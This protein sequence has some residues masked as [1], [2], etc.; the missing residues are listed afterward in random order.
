MRLLFITGNKGK[1]EEVKAALSFVEQFN[2]DLPEIQEIDSR[3]IIKFKLLEALRHKNAGF[4]VEDTSLHLD[5]LN[6][7][8]GPLIRWFL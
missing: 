5:C 8:P 4:I 2:V 6:G 1:F 7:L 3:K